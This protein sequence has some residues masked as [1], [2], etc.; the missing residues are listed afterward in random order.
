MNK[1]ELGETKRLIRNFLRRAAVVA[2]VGIEDGEWSREEAEK[3]VMEYGNEQ[4]SKVLN[5]E[6]DEFMMFAMGEALQTL[7]EH[8]MEGTK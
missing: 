7:G 8:I 5:M 1:K 4:F 6:E 3:F 2:K